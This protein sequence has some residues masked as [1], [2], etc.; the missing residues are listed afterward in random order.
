MSESATG[1]A[2][3]M[4]LSKAGAGVTGR[5]AVSET[6]ASAALAQTSATAGSAWQ[7]VHHAADDWL[8]E[9]PGTHRIF[10]DTVTPEGFSDAVLYAN[11]YRTVGA[12][13]GGPTGNPPSIPPFRLEPYLGSFDHMLSEFWNL[14]LGGRDLRRLVQATSRSS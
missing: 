12:A 9:V 6:G 13:E 3:R 1:M 2:R 5:G 11:N 8:D 4:F 7:P 10:L 14:A